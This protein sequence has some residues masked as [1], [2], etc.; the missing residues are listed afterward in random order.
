MLRFNFTHLFKARGIDRPY[1]FLVKT[2]YS[3]NFATKIANNRIKRLD[4]EKIEKLCELFQ[5][6]PND[7]IEW[8]PSKENKNNKAHPLF[9]LKQSDKVIELTKLMN[10]IPVNKLEEIETIINKEINNNT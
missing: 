3:T 7:V 4:L 10:S 8:I 6:T 9:P 5:C 2:G 1:N